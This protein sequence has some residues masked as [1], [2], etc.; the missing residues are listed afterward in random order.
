MDFSVVAVAIDFSASS[1][2][3]YRRARSLLRN[4]AV[5]RL[6][7]VIETSVF[8]EAPEGTLERLHS[9]LEAAAWKELEILAEEPL[10]NG[11]RIEIRVGEGRPADEIL[12]AAEGASV[13]LVGTEGRGVVGRLILGSVAEEVARRSATPVLV[14]HADD[15]RPIAR[16]LIA[17]DPSGPTS[18][19]VRAGAALARHVGATVEAI[20]SV[21]PPPLLS[22]ARESVLTEMNRLLA[23]RLEQSPRR[24]KEVLAREAGLPDV[25]VHAVEGSPAHEIARAARPGDVVVCGTHARS[26]GDRLLFGSVAAKLIRSVPVPLLVVRPAEDAAPGTLLTS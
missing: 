20:Q 15:A 11:A 3:A 23:A 26:A 25:K 21:P 12:R 10:V 22:Y 18:D 2:A 7:H 13:L 9:D 17:V 4:G 19:V 14:V 16:V 1:L 5:L 6:I 24:V 8:D